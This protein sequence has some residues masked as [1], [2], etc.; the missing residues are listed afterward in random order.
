MQVQATTFQVTNTNATG[1]GSL[2]DAMWAASFDAS[3]TTVAPHV[4]NFSGL[5]I[6]ANTITITGQLPVQRPVILDGATHPAGRVIISA[7]GGNIIPINIYNAGSSPAGTRIRNLVIVNSNA[8]GIQMDGVT[9]VR[10]ENCYIGVLAN[11]TTA[12][13]VQNGVMLFNGANDIQL[14]N[15]VISGNKSN[16]VLIFGATT[17]NIKVEGCKIGVTAVGT[18]ALAN[19]ANGVQLSDF[20]NNNQITNNVIS[21]NGSNGLFCSATISN[22]ITGNKIGVGFNGTTGLGNLANGIQLIDNSTLN[23]LND[24]V[25]SANKSNGVSFVKSTKNIFTNNKIGVTA[26]GL[27]ALANTNNGVEVLDVSN[28]NEFTDNVISANGLIGMRVDKSI[29]TK[30]TGNKIGVGLDGLTALGNSSHGV[31]LFGGSNESVV[32]NNVISANG[33]QGLSIENSNLTTV[34]NNKIGVGINGTT[35][36]GQPQNG[37]QVSGASTNTISGNTIS[38]NGFEGINLLLSSNNN[39]IDNNSIV[40]NGAQGVLI[41]ESNT[42]IISNNVISGNGAKF[43][44]NGVFVKSATGTSLVGNKV[45][46]AANGITKQANNGYGINISESFNTTIGGNSV[47]SRNLISANTASGIILTNS[48]GTNILGNFIG[49]DKTGSTIATNNNHGIEIK[50]ATS[51]NN[52][53]GDVTFL[54]RNVISG[55]GLHG[56]YII[57]EAHDNAIYGNYIGT[58]STGNVSKGNGRNGIS[59]EQAH[60]TTVGGTTAAHRNVISGNGFNEYMTD[61]GPY[62]SGISHYKS[63]GLIVKANFIGLGADGE[64][65]IPNANYGIWYLESNTLTVGGILASERN[66]ISGNGS[67]GLNPQANQ[68]SSPGGQSSRGIYIETANTVSILG[69]YIGTNASGTVAKPN[70]SDG[71]VIINSSAVTVGGTTSA[72][73]NVISGNSHSGLYLNN[74]TTVSVQNNI[75]GLSADGKTKLA[76]ALDGIYLN[77]Q[78]NASIVNNTTSGNSHTGIHLYQSNSNALTN[79]LIGISKDKLTT[80]GNTDGGIRIVGTSGGNQNKVSLNTITGGTG[81]NVG[82]TVG[83]GYGVYVAGT[84]ANQNSISQNAIYCNAGLAIN[85]QLTGTGFGATTAGN[86]GKVIPVIAPSLSTSTSTSGTGVVGDTIQLYANPSKCGCGGEVYLGKTVVAANGK[87]QFT[88]PAND[89][90]WVSALAISANGNTSQFSCKKAVAGKVLTVTPNCINAPV[91]LVATAYSATDL[92]W[93]ISTASD[94]STIA[95]SVT[96]KVTAD[97]TTIQFTPSSEVMHYARITSIVSPTER[98]ISAVTSWQVSASQSLGNLLSATNQLCTSDSVQLTVQNN[99]ATSYAW[100]DSTATQGWQTISGTTASRYVKPIVTTAYRVTAT[101]GACLLPSSIKTITVIPQVTGSV[102][103][104]I[105]KNDVCEGTAMK[106]T[107]TGTNVGSKAIYT[108]KISGEADVVGK[109]LDRT[110]TN[111]QTI[112]MVVTPDTVCPNKPTYTTTAIVTKVNPMLNLG[113]IKSG[114][115]S[116]CTGDSLLLEVGN[117]VVSSYIWSDSTSSRSWQ[118]IAGKTSASLFVK[119]LVKTAYKVVPSSG[120]CVIP[121]TI[122]TIDVTSSVVGSVSIA[123][124]QNDVCNGTQ[125]E[126]VA[127]GVNVGANAVYTWK[128]SGEADV[129]AKTLKRTFTDAQTVKVVVTPDVTCSTQP[130]YTSNEILVKV[131]PVFNFGTIKASATTLCTGDSLQISVENNVAAPYTWFDSTATQGWQAL[132]GKTSAAIYVKPAVTTAYKFQPTTGNCYLPIAPFTVTVKAKVIGSISLSANKNS[133][134]SGDEIVFTANALNVGKG[135]VYTWKLDGVTQGANSFKFSP[136]NLKSG[137]E[138]QV[139]VSPDTACPSTLEYASNVYTAVVA[140]KENPSVSINA[141]TE[142]CAGDTVEVT[143]NTSNSALS[144]GFRWFVNAIETDSTRTTYVS[145]SFKAGDNIQLVMY[146]SGECMPDSVVS[147]PLTITSSPTG[148]FVIAIENYT[149]CLKEQGTVSLNASSNLGKESMDYEWYVNGVAQLNNDSTFTFI[150]KTNDVITVGASTEIA[151]LDTDTTNSIALVMDFSLPVTA[152]AGKDVFI[153]ELEEVQLS[154]QNSINATN[155]LWQE[156]VSKNQLSNVGLTPAVTVM[157]KGIG[158]ATYLLT[159]SNKYC[160]DTATVNVVLSIDLF[161]PNAFSPNKDD[162]NDRWTLTN[163]EAFEKIEIKVF[164]RWGTLLYHSPKGAYT[165]TSAWDGTYNGEALPVATYYYIVDL[166]NGSEPHSGPVTIIR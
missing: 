136:T 8:N 148:P 91:N 147:N 159:A 18:T 85:L 58:D 69:N 87:W 90:L 108:W 46:L 153:E 2:S 30:I 82:S 41:S 59:G 133:S 120:A 51:F 144:T 103:I 60:K 23:T 10:V 160:S 70:L 86:N 94:F 105:D 43:S 132:S 150:P 152:D 131:N 64:K 123:V 104:A 73:G 14:N 35:A 98:A 32:T 9:N 63:D 62:F 75:L 118:V 143:S 53:I 89:S 45:G 166:H 72:A 84:T 121:P 154:A 79:N 162:V 119:P 100:A 158:T 149:K 83:N 146:T 157:P 36:L 12:S 74:N 112:N 1:V 109:V 126:F 151:C 4:I 39:T 113:N 138:V 128:I 38:N 13:G 16:G 142:I 165:R 81:T 122:T 34:S 117:N 134:C 48:S 19:G 101:S 77:A 40:A 80:I 93:E 114:Q 111:G 88:H 52:K 21:A 29:K 44:A 92:L 107:A 27:T 110:F 137:Q 5:A 25:V 57:E 31:Q 6:G 37:I 97:T 3:A 164:N 135:A 42:T 56:V 116:I 78:N 71:V 124:D 20:T 99:L 68:L 47:A 140:Q 96:T 26:T 145:S 102:T 49:L 129:V 106:F 161:I 7:G 66:V 28:E 139:L 163:A 33:I 11:G 17:K 141:D 67:A 76:N 65:I 24:N 15:C 54:G 50:G 156:V 155:Y 55:N 127:T 95:Y 125:M 22:T 130:F 115:T 61:E